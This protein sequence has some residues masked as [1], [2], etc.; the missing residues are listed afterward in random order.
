MLPL[1][2]TCHRAILRL[3]IKF[4]SFS[5]KHGFGYV[6]RDIFKNKLIILILKISDNRIIIKM[7]KYIKF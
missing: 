3:R 7:V 2:V 6:I 4:I 5:I 1:C